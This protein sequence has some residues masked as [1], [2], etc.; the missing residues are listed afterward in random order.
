M[1][2]TTILN[3]TE[4]AHKVRRIAYQIY[5]SNVDE[6]EVVVAGIADNG[7]ILAQKIALE[8]QQISAIKIVLCKVKMDKSNIFEPVITSVEE[9]DYQGKSLILVDDVL[10]TGSVLMYAVKHFLNVPLKQIK[11]AVLVDRNHKKFPIKVDFK[12][13]S[14][15]TT[16][17]NR[18]EVV[19]LNEK[20][21]AYLI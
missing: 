21:E 12:G 14:L 5:E 15:S 13:I 9:N 8:L 10:H 6:S 17:Q 18:V 7:Y 11:T 2:K 1:S 16:F 4:I 3:H 19:F 20:D